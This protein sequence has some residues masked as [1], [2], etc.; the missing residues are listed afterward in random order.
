MKNQPVKSPLESSSDVK[1]DAD[2]SPP[3]YEDLK[4]GAPG[5]VREGPKN[6]LQRA[7]WLLR[8]AGIVNKD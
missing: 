3:N 2:T 7:K 8:R 1:R 4:K 5:P 6:L